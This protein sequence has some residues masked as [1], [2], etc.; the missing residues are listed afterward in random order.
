MGQN[1]KAKKMVDIEEVLVYCYSDEVLGQA[2]TQ[3]LMKCSRYMDL[4]V[5]LFLFFC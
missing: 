4:F 5:C 2:A 3:K 1:E